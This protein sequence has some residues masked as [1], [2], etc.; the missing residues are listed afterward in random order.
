M[1]QLMGWLG[2]LNFILMLV[3]VMPLVSGCFGLTLSVH[4][5]VSFSPMVASMQDAARKVGCIYLAIYD[6]SVILYWLAGLSPEAAVNQ[7]W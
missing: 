5:S 2:G 1:A 4:Q 7:G 3:S 6:L